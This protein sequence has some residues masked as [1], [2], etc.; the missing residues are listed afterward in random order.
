MPALYQPGEE[1]GAYLLPLDL[2]A[3]AMLR[4][5]VWISPDTA[6]PVTTRLRQLLSDPNGPLL[7][8]FRRT[9]P[10]LIHNPVLRWDEQRRAE[11]DVLAAAIGNHAQR[12]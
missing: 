12:R 6:M 1:G 3:L 5:A 7:Q 10:W 8:A 4:H 11:L 2:Q 9:A